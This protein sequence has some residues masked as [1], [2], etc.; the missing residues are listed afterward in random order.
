MIEILVWLCLIQIIGTI[1][2]IV[3]FRLFNI[4][5]DRGYGVS[6]ILG[7]LMFAF[8][9]WMLGSFGILPATSFVLWTWLILLV[10]ISVII[11]YSQRYELD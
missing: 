5:P 4:L 7:L 9:V 6:K 2:F 8:P 11:S 10:G 3:N 1:S